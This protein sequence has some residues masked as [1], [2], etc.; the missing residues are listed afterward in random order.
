METVE[1]SAS[2]A[3]NTPIPGLDYKVRYA[4][5]DKATPSTN[6]SFIDELTPNSHFYD[7]PVNRNY[8]SVHVP[9][10]VYDRS[11][12]VQFYNILILNIHYYN[13]KVGNIIL[14]MIFLNNI[15]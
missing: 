8:S 11:K 7:I 13:I 15:L 12:L 5:P 9:T 4:K 1:V 3:Q 2:E 14:L 6:L 10:Y